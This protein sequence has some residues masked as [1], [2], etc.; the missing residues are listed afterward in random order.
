M[1]RAFIGLG[2]AATALIAS[3]ALAAPAG[4]P[5]RGKA[6]YARCSICHAVAPGAKSIGPNL[7]G[8]TKR[9]SASVKGFAYSPALMRLNVTWNSSNLDKFIASPQKLAPGSKMAFTGMADPAQRA[10]LIAYLETL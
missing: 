6:L 8:I 2:L 7:A 3:A 9:K 5:V 1:V 10:D 4:D